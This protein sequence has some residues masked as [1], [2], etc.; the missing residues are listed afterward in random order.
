MDR[1]PLSLLALQLEDSMEDDLADASVAGVTPSTDTMSYAELTQPAPSP[2]DPVVVD[3]VDLL[4]APVGRGAQGTVQETRGLQ[5][6]EVEEDG[7]DPET[8]PRMA[9]DPP[10]QRRPAKL[11]GICHAASC[12]PPR[13]AY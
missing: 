3:P 10:V 7:F 11:M 4:T 5:V 2:K 1:P 6:F 13:R 9:C 12:A 8:D